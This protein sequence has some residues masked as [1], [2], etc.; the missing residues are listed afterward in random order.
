MAQNATI[1]AF[2]EAYAAS[3]KQQVMPG[4]FIQCDRVFGTNIAHETPEDVRRDRR[5]S[6]EFGCK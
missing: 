3:M 6:I 5:A 4:H 2:R 1:S